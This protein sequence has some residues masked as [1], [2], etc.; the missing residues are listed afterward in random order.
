ML[1]RDALVFSSPPKRRSVGQSRRDAYRDARRRKLD[2]EC[3][4]R[5][6]CLRDQ[7]RTL[8]EIAADLGVSH[9]TVRSVLRG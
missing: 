7:G 1:P 4:R 3:R 9:E 8:W 5:I 6:G 2:D